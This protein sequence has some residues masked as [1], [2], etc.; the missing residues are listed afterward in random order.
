MLECEG[1]S[2]GSTIEKGRTEA[3]PIPIIEKPEC[4]NILWG[5]MSISKSLPTASKQLMAR[6][7]TKEALRHAVRSS[8]NGCEPYLDL[9]AAAWMQRC[10]ASPPMLIRD[11]GTACLVTVHFIGI[12]RDS[13]PTNSQ[14]FQESAPIKRGIIYTNLLIQRLLSRLAWPSTISSRHPTQSQISPKNQRDGS[15]SGLHTRRLISSSKM[16]SA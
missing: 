8:T 3:Y 16:T 14:P 12:L 11:L 7:L 5:S 2:Y 9:D 6:S 15:T 1:G 13:L 10:S 4:T